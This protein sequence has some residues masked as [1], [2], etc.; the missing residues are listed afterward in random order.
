LLINALFPCVSEA[1]CGLDLTISG[2][3]KSF[4]FPLPLLQG[5]FQNDPFTFA[6]LDGGQ[7]GHAVNFAT[8]EAMSGCVAASDEAGG[9]GQ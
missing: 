1:L 4:I 8:A 9:L 2:G 7:A 5:G 3:G 6:D